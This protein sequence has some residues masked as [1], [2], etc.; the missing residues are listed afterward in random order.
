LRSAPPLSEPLAGVL[1]RALAK[2]GRVAEALETFAVTRQAEPRNLTHLLRPPA[3]M[4][5]SISAKSCLSNPA[6]ASAASAQSS[7]GVYRPR[8]IAASMSRKS[9]AAARL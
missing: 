1:T 6:S 3:I 5:P 7:S 8:V 4:E 9:R 2:A